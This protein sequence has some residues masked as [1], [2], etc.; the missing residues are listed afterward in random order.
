MSRARTYW[1]LL[2]GAVIFSGCGQQSDRWKAQR[3]TV[4]PA[5]G[6]VTFEGLPLEGAVVVFQPTAPDG[7]GASALT[8]SDGKFELKTFPPESGAVP[9]SY[10]VVIMKTDAEDQPSEDAAPV[11]VKSLIPIKYSIAAKS[12]LVADI[13][14]SGLENISFDLKE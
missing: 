2:T 14:P 12:G 5:S 13:P 11:M 8:D 7:I 9:G 4:A 10:S 1:L 6:T 3:P